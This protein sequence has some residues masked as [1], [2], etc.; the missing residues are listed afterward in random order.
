MN[1]GRAVSRD[2]RHGACLRRR[3]DAKKSSLERLQRLRI[4]ASREGGVMPRRTDRA[5]PYAWLIFAVLVLA[6]LAAAAGEADPGK[7]LYL[8]YCGACHGPTGKGDGIVS[9]FMEPRPPDLTRLAQKAGGTFPFLETMRI[10]DGRDSRRAHGDPD[11]P[12]WGEILRAP[13]G[14]SGEQSVE[15]AGKLLMITEHVRS[16][17]R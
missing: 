13:E 9:H 5:R 15:L 16:L 2:T 7:A 6:P 4:A 8:K 17:Q 14:V 12:V 11:M 1:F 10:I 3:F